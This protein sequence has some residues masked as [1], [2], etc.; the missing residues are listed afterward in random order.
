MDINDE[1]TSD[2][3]EKKDDLVNP[4][5][6]SEQ[7]NEH[8]SEQPENIKDDNNEVLTDENKEPDKKEAG[9]RSF[10]GKK[11]KTLN[12][13]EIAKKLEVLLTEHEELTKKFEEQAEKLQEMND[14]YLRTTAEFDNFRKRTAK[15]KIDLIKYGGENVLM[16]IIPVID[17]FERAMQAIETAKDI[18]PI[19]EGIFLI[20]AKFTE[21]L[22]QKGI[23]EIEAVNLDFNT[24]VHEAITKIPAPGEEMK[25][26]VVDVVEKGYMLYDKVIRFSKVVVG[27]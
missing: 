21:L 15:E 3:A 8:N 10:F 5:L 19:K 23:K 18:E 12:A 20:Y 25:G 11:T 16:D 27:E 22:K 7:E 13:D 1:L 17:N 2:N 6:S 9:K 26:K 4:E 24:D 14:R